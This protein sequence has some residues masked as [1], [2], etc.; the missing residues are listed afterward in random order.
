MKLSNRLKTTLVLVLS[1]LAVFVGLMN[2]TD[3]A[4]WRHAS[5]GVEWLE[6][7]RGLEVG[8]VSP[9]LSA[10]H[11]GL[12]QGMLLARVNGI[13]VGGQDD[14]TEIREFLAESL[15]P[16]TP[17]TYVIQDGSGD[18][19]SFPFFISLQ[20]SF[21][22]SD[23]F[24]AAVAFGF[25]IVG[26]LIFLR[27]W[28]ASGAFHFYLICL[29]AFVAFL[30]RHSGHANPLDV[31]VFIADVVAFLLLPPIFLHFCLNF[32]RP[33]SWFRPLLIVY[34]PALLVGATFVGWLTGWLQPFGFPRTAVMDLV[35]QQVHLVHFAAFFTLGTAALIRNWQVSVTSMQRQQM[36]WIAGGA[37]LGVG[38]FLLL[39]AVPYVMHWRTTPWMEA[40]VLGLVLV[41]LSFGY[42]I[43]RYRLM[44]VE[45]IFRKSAAYIL[46]SSVLVAAYVGIV[47]LAGRVFQN[48]L[49]DSGFLFFAF[50]ALAIAFL[51]A[52]LNT[53][54][55]QQI[56]RYFYKDQY[57]Y[58]QSFA[59]FVQTLNSEVDLALLAEKICERIQKTLNISPVVIFLRDNPKLSSYHLYRARGE[60]AE[61]SEFPRLELED[62]TLESL[63]KTVRLFA[64]SESD[65]VTKARESLRGMGFQYT[66]PLRTQERLIGFIA[67]GKPATGEFLTSEDLQL[68][69]T[70]GGYAAIA[71]DNASLYRS[72]EVN[73]AE[74]AELKVYSDNVIESITVGVMVVSRDGRVTIWNSQMESTFGIQRQDATGRD[75]SEVLPE[76]LVDT[77]HRSLGHQ[78]WDI[79]ATAHIQKTH[80]RSTT[81]DVRLVDIR[82]APFVSTQSINI[83]TLLVF[84]DI[85]DKARL[86]DQLTQAEKLSSIGLFAAGVAHEVNTPLAGISSY[87]QMLIKDTSEADPNRD[88]LER[89]EKQSFRASN[90]IN[91]LLNFARVKDTDL[92]EVN[93]N[94]LMLDTL[95]LLD[96]PFR[97]AKVDVEVDLDPRLP[98][99]VGNGGKLQQVFMNLFLNAKDAMPKG[100]HLKIQTLSRDSSLVVRIQDNGEGIPDEHIRKIY[101]PFFSTKA[102]GEGTGLGL[103]VSYGIIQEHS[104]RISVDSE[105]GRGTVFTVELP[106]KRIN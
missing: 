18:E 16:G 83:G 58:R 71:I 96:H 1:G 41:P 54:I 46:A 27:N 79:D 62:E 47:V 55:Q 69:E 97:R 88:I 29:M 99:T 57:D 98:A 68:L 39:Y 43:S 51:F 31:G 75:V 104:G 25:L 14:L 38:P 48:I 90:I 7:H 66:Q 65:E 60:V 35:Q 91:N 67:L 106:L 30:F 63:Q 15:A 77:I 56:D 34:L 78:R 94:S 100:G 72:L 86:E 102:V 70:L 19:S 52:P 6:T 105:H 33:I 36:K 80:V 95:S 8:K 28:A 101:D 73:A 49:G 45:L 85:T 103:S 50:G 84:D 9:E 61:D 59:S 2:L 11:P 37:A 3:R 92:T 4:N 26:L 24:L 5:D 81:G 42:A 53:R 13:P 93:L 10:Q 89:I 82:L 17:A 23:L 87:T 20:S 22:T 44:D 74:L 40:S 32:P 12:K 76:D 21:R 64:A